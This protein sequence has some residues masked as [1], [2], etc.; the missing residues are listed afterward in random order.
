MNQRVLGVAFAAFAITSSHVLL[1]A[2]PAEAACRQVLA[3]NRW[4]YITV[5]DGYRGGADYSG[6]VAAGI[7]AG[8]MAL[9]LLPGVLG[10]V[11]D[12]TSGVGDLTAGAANSLSN[13]ASN[14]TAPL[15]ETPSLNPFNIFGSQP[16]VPC[17]ANDRRHGCRNIRGNAAAFGENNTAGDQQYVVDPGGC[18]AN[19]A[20]FG[21][22]QKMQP[23]QH[24]YASGCY[25]EYVAAPQP[26]KKKTKKDEAETPSLQDRLK[27][28]LSREQ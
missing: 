10:T 5:C 6:A 28:M 8:V 13:A 15:Q 22:C 21:R 16:D 1:F 2:S 26:A 20:V 27:L 25:T 4:Q 24:C 18:D 17:S 23:R 19:K 7:T 12:V 3:P 14:A 11:G 9:E